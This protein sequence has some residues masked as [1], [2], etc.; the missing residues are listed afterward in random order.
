MA[1]ALR[2]ALARDSDENGRAAARP[3]PAGRW[4]GPRRPPERSSGGGSRWPN[5]NDRE[6]AAAA[7]GP[8]RLP[9]GRQV[10]PGSKEG[11]ADACPSRSARAAAAAATGGPGP[12]RRAR[13]GGGAGGRGTGTRGGW[14]GCWQDP[15]P[16]P[17]SRWGRRIRRPTRTVRVLTLAS[18]RPRGPPQPSTAAAASSSPPPPLLVQIRAHAPHC[19][20]RPRQP[21]RRPRQLAGGASPPSLHSL[22]PGGD[23]PHPP[24][25]LSASRDSWGWG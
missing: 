22:E 18:P 23:S 6:W 4:P 21:P 11:L 19:A 2:D 17:S 9:C 5:L 25:H 10:A 8:S 14:Q 24:T 12:I 7:G 1:R 13:R 16:S 20:C 3:G 15:P